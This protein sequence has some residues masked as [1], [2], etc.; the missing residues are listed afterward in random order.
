MFCGNHEHIR[1]RLGA[2]ETCSRNKENR[3]FWFCSSSRQSLT[4][5]TGISPSVK[6]ILLRGVPTNSTIKTYLQASLRSCTSHQFSH[7]T[8]TGTNHNGCFPTISRKP[9]EVSN[10]HLKKA[11]NFKLLQKQKRVLALGIFIKQAR[12]S[13]KTCHL[14]PLPAVHTLKIMWLGIGCFWTHSS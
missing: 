12:Y 5:L 1:R 9:N 11:N 10:G 2:A 6:M 13:T 3:M 8:G 4:G 14:N 7:W